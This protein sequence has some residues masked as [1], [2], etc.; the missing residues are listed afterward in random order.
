MP[1][2]LFGTQID[3]DAFFRYNLCNYKKNTSIMLGS[4]NNVFDFALSISTKYLCRT[5]R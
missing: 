5:L 4:L 3:R 1:I 2:N